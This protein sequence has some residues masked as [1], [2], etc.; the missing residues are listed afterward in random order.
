MPNSAAATA[1]IAT[2]K[3]GVCLVSTIPAMR[4]VMVPKV[5]PGPMI[6]G[7]TPL[8]GSM[9]GEAISYAFSGSLG[10]G[11]RTAAIYVVR[12]RVFSSASSWYLRGLLL[13]FDTALSLL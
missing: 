3:M 2:Q 8:G 10:L 1:T 4:S 13:S 7:L 9:S 12:G 5:W 6:G 11:F